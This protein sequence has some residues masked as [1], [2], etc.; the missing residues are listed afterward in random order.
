MNDYLPKKEL[1]PEPD[2]RR[3][4]NG[5]LAIWLIV[6]GVAVYMIVSGIIGIVSK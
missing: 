4:S 6:G 2:K 1:E 5:R 3:V